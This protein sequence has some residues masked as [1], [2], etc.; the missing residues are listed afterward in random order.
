MESVRKKLTILVTSCPSSQ[1]QAVEGKVVM[2]FTSPL[3][4]HYLA[5][6]AYRWTAL[7]EIRI[8]HPELSQV[9]ICMDTSS[10][11]W[12]ALYARRNVSTVLPLLNAP[13]DRHRRQA[14][15]HSTMTHARG[16]VNHR[17]SCHRGRRERVS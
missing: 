15:V 12:N 9:M 11:Y 7:S 1:C 8:Q 14:I 3:K 17:V 16:N 2:L 4:V 6:D 13:I 5:D 10:E